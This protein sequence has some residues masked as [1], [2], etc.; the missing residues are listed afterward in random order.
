MGMVIM[1]QMASNS[2]DNMLDW[3]FSGEESDEE[4]DLASF[5][6]SYKRPPLTDSRTIAKD[7]FDISEETKGEEDDVKSTVSDDISDE[8]QVIGFGFDDGFDKISF[9]EDYEES[10]K[11][12]Y[13]GKVP[14]YVGTNYFN[15][16]PK[17]PE[18]TVN[19]EINKEPQVPIH[20]E[21][22][23]PFK[24]I[25][26]PSGASS[27]TTASLTNDVME[28]KATNQTTTDSEKSNFEIQYT[29]QELF[30]L[31]KFKN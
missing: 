27:M 9:R 29:P 24:Y 12:I 22:N 13:A 15:I 26:I 3:R 1:F 5:V 11:I 4:I 19:N 2:N 17:Y 18:G 28:E 10:S 14:I 31:H 6:E 8:L 21:N 23:N 7:K 30:V 20:Y 25:K 16:K